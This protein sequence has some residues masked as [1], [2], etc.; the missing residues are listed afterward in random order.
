[1]LEFINAMG[2]VCMVITGFTGV[3]TLF[4]KPV[5]SAITKR[6]EKK[7]DRTTLAILYALITDI[8]RDRI[9]EKELTTA[10]RKNLV[11]LYGAYKAEGGN[12]YVEKIYN[13]MMSWPEIL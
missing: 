7:K 11:Y 8:Y 12:G 5:R 10:D 1:M 6:F 2:S 9:G 4:C 13:E 3:L